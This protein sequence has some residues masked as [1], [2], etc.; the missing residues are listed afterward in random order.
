MRLQD[1]DEAVQAYQEAC[2]LETKHVQI[3]LNRYMRLQE[4][5]KAVQA[6]QEARKLEHKQAGDR[7]DSDLAGKIGQVSF[8]TILGLF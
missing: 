4:P 6:Y 1:P 2:K 7:G 3:K 8:D 5:D